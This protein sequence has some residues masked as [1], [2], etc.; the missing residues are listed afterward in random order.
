[1]LDH[2]NTE[3][4]TITAIGE[5]AVDH[6]FIKKNHKLRYIGSTGGGSASNIIC[7]L[8]ALGNTTNV[9]GV[10]GD[11]NN[12]RIALQ[13]F[14]RFE[15]NT[16]GLIFEKSLTTT[17][18][19]HIIFQNAKKDHSFSLVCPKC[20]QQFPNPLTFKRSHIRYAQKEILNKSNLIIVDGVSKAYLELAKIA[21][22]HNIPIIIDLGTTSKHFFKA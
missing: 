18:I 19:A 20:K 4:S 11:D 16:D 5:V 22:K 6:L 7:Y 15:V 17:Q 21:Y 2:R 12:A 14:E 8:A 10:I 1:M 9:I 13:D 3:L